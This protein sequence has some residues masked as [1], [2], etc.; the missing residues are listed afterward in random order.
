[1]FTLMVTAKQHDYPIYIGNNLLAQAELFQPLIKSQQ[2]LIVTQAN[3]AELYL[4]Q[5]KAHFSDK[6]CDVIYLQEGEQHKDLSQWMRIFDELIEKKHHR[7]TTLIALGGGIIG[8]ITGFAAA[9]YQRG[10]DFLQ[11]PTSLLAQVDASI[12]GKTGVN[13]QHH[14][15]MIGAFYPPRAVFIDVDVLTTLPARDLAA[16]WAEIIKHALI[17]DEAFFNWIEE[18][19][20]DLQNV[21]P[22][23]YIPAIKRSCEIKAAIVAQDE[24]EQQQRAILNFGHTFAH[25]LESLTAYHLLHGE[26]VALGMMMA[27]LLSIHLGYLSQNTVER[28]AR[29]LKA[30]HLP[31]SPPISFKMADLLQHIEYDKKYTDAGLTV[32]VLEKVGV[33]KIIKGLPVTDIITALTQDSPKVV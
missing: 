31:V 6:Q 20:A 28:I 29:L 24:Y 7:S 15:N 2:L 5:L 14:K 23:W 32:I 9:C 3:I 8:D 17:Y 13:Y 21:N 11:I 10:V 25:A 18:H 4:S 16:G 30:F 26:A 1:M 19:Q 33:A 27:S 12:G 22:V